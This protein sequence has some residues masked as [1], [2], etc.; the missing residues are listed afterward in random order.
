MPDSLHYVHRSINDPFRS[1]RVSTDVCLS[2]GFQHDLSGSIRITAFALS[3]L[4]LIM[5]LWFQQ[6]IR[7]S[8][9]LLLREVWPRELASFHRPPIHDSAQPAD[10]PQHPRI[11]YIPILID[12]ILPHPKLH[13]LDNCQHTSFLTRRRPAL[14]LRCRQKFSFDA[15]NCLFY[16]RGFDFCAR[17]GRKT[18]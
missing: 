1:L 2:H 17:G 14:K 13:S 11:D 5:S 7:L 4:S 12:R 8:L 10:R 15:E 16:A 3:P 6:T 9:L 18:T